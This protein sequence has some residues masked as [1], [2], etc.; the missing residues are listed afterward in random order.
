MTTKKTASRA[1]QVKSSAMAFLEDLN[2]GPLTFGDLLGAIRKGDEISQTDFAEKLG[3]S[4]A[5]LCDIEKGRRTVSPARA[6]IWGKKLG[7]SPE[8]FVELAIQTGLDHDKIP[9]KVR[10]EVA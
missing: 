4:K 9:F 1:K 3:V 10:L 8:Q 2:G 6:Y 5:H 7:Y